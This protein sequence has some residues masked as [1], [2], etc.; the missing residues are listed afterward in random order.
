MTDLINNAGIS[1]PDHPKE[2]AGS[3]SRS[4]MMEVFNTNVASVAAIT[5]ASGVLKSSDGKV[6]NISSG[7]GSS[8][9]RF[10]SSCSPRIEPLVFLIFGSFE[11]F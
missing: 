4:Q 3:I 10:G 9:S 5:S 8:V 11:T 2:T 1:T 7:M 6:I